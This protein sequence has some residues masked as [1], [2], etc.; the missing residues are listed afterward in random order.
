MAA[1]AV[2]ILCEEGHAGAEYVV[3]GPQSLTQTEQVQTIGRA[4]GRSLRLEEIPPDEA[5]SELLPALGSLAPCQKARRGSSS[6]LTENRHVH[7]GRHALRLPESAEV[8]P[9]DVN[10]AIR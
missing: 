3:T 7:L 8:K 5:R 9:D 6:K 2:R 4:I 1:V 10:L